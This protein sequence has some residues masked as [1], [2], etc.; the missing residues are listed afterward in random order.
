MSLPFLTFPAGTVLAYALLV[1]SHVTQGHNYTA[2][3]GFTGSLWT[4]AAEQP[5]ALSPKLWHVEPFSN[6]ALRGSQLCAFK[7]SHAEMT[8][9]TSFFLACSGF[10][11][12][13]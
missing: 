13:L 10:P 6:S 11:W 2:G 1:W 8:L 9:W 3:S 7:K 5:M 12:A 4:A